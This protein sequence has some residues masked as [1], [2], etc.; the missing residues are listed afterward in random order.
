MNRMTLALVGAMAAALLTSP[1]LAAEPTSKLV[2]CGEQ[3]CLRVAGYR[4]DPTAVVWINGHAV[5]AE[6]ERNW[7]VHL[8]LDVVREW[9]VPN[10]RTIEVS[11]GDEDNQPEAGASVDLPIGLLADEAVLASLVLNVR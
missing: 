4:E 3:S 5:D 6:G 10:A 1:A 9:S 7:K 11:L 2:R 8:P